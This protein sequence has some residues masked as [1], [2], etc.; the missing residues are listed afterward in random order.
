VELDALA[1]GERVRELSSEIVQLLARSG[2]GSLVSNEM[3]DRPRQMQSTA[4]QSPNEV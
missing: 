2:V 1:Q 3:K 4:I